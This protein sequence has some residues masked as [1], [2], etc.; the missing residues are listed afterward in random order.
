MQLQLL[1]FIMMVGALA[2]W[3][4][5]AATAPATCALLLA[6][7]GLM[8][9]CASRRSRYLRRLIRQRA[10]LGLATPGYHLGRPI[11]DGIA[12]IPV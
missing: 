3:S 9:W 2:T 7:L 4:A 5:D 6:A 1:A 12:G 8:L 11:A 10:R